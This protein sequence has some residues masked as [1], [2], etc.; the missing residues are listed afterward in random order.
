MTA[1]DPAISTTPTPT[2]DAPDRLTLTVTIAGL[3]DV[4]TNTIRAVGTDVTL[5]SLSRVRLHVAD[6]RLHATSTDRYR[7]HR[8]WTPLLD[9]TLA[10]LPAPLMVPADDVAALRTMLRRF[11]IAA[12]RD[13]PVALTVDPPNPGTDLRLIQITT[14]TRICFDPLTIHS[15]DDPT[16]PFPDIAALDARTPRWEPTGTVRLNPGFLADAAKL[17]HHGRPVSRHAGLTLRFRADRPDRALGAV[18]ITHPGRPSF[19][20]DVMPI[21][22]HAR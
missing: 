19:T 15:L 12:L 4:L 20:A 21:H 2:D 14:S 13:E 7:I 16:S 8:D 5:P 22:H 9:N 3:F 18:R 11:R 6:G 17:T 1:T 10:R